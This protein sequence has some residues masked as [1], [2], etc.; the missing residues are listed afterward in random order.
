MSA[1]VDVL[2]LR[3]R[4]GWSQAQLAR[5][6]GVSDRSVARW[7]NGSAPTGPSADWLRALEDVVQTS[8]GLGS[9]RQALDRGENLTSLVRRVLEQG[10][11]KHG[12][13]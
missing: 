7:E 10:E 6:M 9:V 11:T 13:R 1:T 2:K 8:V 12:E 4:L 5:F 3:E